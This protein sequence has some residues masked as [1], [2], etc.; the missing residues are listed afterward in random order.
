MEH[1][2]FN[3]LCSGFSVANTLKGHGMPLVLETNGED[4]DALYTAMRNS[5][6]TPGPTAVIAYRK[7]APTIEVCADERTNGYRA[8]CLP[9]G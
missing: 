9:N 4:L 6:V 2:L 1:H 3:L 7:M 5:I 8:T